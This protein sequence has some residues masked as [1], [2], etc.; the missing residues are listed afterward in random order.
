MDHGF[1]MLSAVLKRA[2][3]ETFSMDLR[4]FQSWDHF[5]TTLKKQTF[6]FTLVS[7]FSANE[8]FAR[9]AVEIVKRN[10]PNKYIIGGGIHLSVTQTSEYPNIDTIVLGEGEPHIIEIADVISAGKKPAP[11]YDLKMV[12]DLDTL[13]WVDRALFNPRMEQTSPLL[14][15]MP[16]PFITIV[17]G[18]GCWGKCTFCAPSRNLISGDKVRIRSV[19]NFIGELLAIRKNGGIGSVMIHDDLLG[20]KKWLGEFIEKWGKNLNHI[21]WWCQLR[22]DTIIKMKE[23]IPDLADIGLTYVSV[24]LESGSQRMLDFLQKGVTVEQNIEACH[25]LHE[26]GINIFGN[27]IVGLPTETPDDL[28]Q[29]EKMLSQIRPEFHSASTYTSYPGSYL[30][31]WIK[32]NNYW[33]DPEEHYC[34]TRFPFERKIKGVDYDYISKRGVQWRNLYTSDLRIPKLKN[35][36]PV[37]MSNDGKPKASVI[38]VTYNRPL[39]LKQA[40]QSIFDQTLKDWELIIIDYTEDH[41]INEQ[42]YEWALQD[43]RV[44]CILHDTNINNIALCWN[45]GLDL[46]KGEFWCTLDD[47]NTKYPAFLEKM[48]GFLETH[49]E[50]DAVICAMEHTG[51]TKGRHFQK[52]KDWDHLKECN[53]IDS[54]Q[55]LYRKSIIERIGYFDERL[56]AYEDWDYIL[57]VYA[58]HE[59]SGTAFGWVDDMLCTYS[60]HPDKRMFSKEIEEISEDFEIAVRDKEIKNDLK[61]NMF[62][63]AGGQTESQKQ[64]AENVFEAL[65]SIPFVK[66][67]PDDPDYIFLMGPLYNFPMDQVKKIKETYPQAKLIGLCCEDP[68][69]LGANIEYL[70]YLDHIVTNDI[71]AYYYYFT[72]QR[73]EGLGIV[74]YWNALSISNKLL[75]FIQNYNPPKI[76]DVCF[77]GYPYPSRI[78]FINELFQLLPKNKFLFIGNTWE[79]YADERKELKY[80]NAC[81]EVYPTL[82]EIETAKIAVQSKII[83]I[84]HRTEKDIGG[85]KI[86]PPNSINRGYIE[87]AY[88]SVLLIDDN[89]T[90]HSFAPG[91]VLWYNSV[92]TCA[93]LIKKVLKNYNQYQEAM[94]GIAYNQAIEQFTHKVRLTKLLNCIRSYRFNKKIE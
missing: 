43:I 37:S 63:W 89:R 13:P 3:H 66:I 2:G 70:P 41:S 94:S 26:S 34:Q 22:A 35:H 83:L 62:S 68:Q 33:A 81:S 44:K 73:P 90:W 82:N 53:K 59:K 46:A 64:L 67:T 4:S 48:T 15:G 40:I 30:Y 57:R 1:A 87:A 24:G 86:V 71:N 11:V 36:F 38:I 17:A 60:W 19:D 65:Q 79:K 45:E 72:K 25:I 58:L 93:R 77:I 76:F 61:V 54:G 12:K 85:F 8:R 56:R 50:N 55:V 78:E 91:T 47:D 74:Q 75:E 39:M 51:T 84:K 49:P 28:D 23:F 31:N 92:E 7:F 16:M 20:S 29:T 6:D 88:R 27:Y 42:V 21:P 18:R 69:A 5:E 10:F 14:A 80:F 32:E 9:Q 52:P